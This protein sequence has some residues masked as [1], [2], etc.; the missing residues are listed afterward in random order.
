VGRLDLFG[1]LPA[2]LPMR[3]AGEARSLRALERGVRARGA[4]RAK[5]YRFGA[6]EAA[7]SEQMTALMAFI[8]AHKAHR[9][10]QIVVQF[11]G[12][13]MRLS[14]DKV[15]LEIGGENLTFDAA[16]EPA[17]CVAVE[18]VA[19]AIP[20]H[21]ESVETLVVAQALRRVLVRRLPDHPLL[22]GLRR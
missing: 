22:E 20:L 15:A 13:V 2:V 21:D 12:G 19:R 18:T 10:D 3:V 4:D 7:A 11:E 17:L 14:A 8:E 6:P 9:N 16:D 5:A 1:P